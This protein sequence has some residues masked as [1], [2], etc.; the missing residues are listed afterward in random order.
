MRTMGFEGGAQCVRTRSKRR[1]LHSMAVGSKKKSHVVNP[2]L[3]RTLSIFGRVQRADPERAPWKYPENTRKTPCK[4]PESHDLSAPNHKSQIA[5]D[6]KS[7]SPNRKNFPQIAV[8]SSSNRTFNRAMC[9]LNLCSYSPLESQCQF[10][11]QQVRTLRFSDKV[12]T[13]S[14]R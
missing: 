8:S 12:H 1:H 3:V 2:P 13:V 14:N 9:D 6:L 10:L 7:R 11:I 4:Y 5:S